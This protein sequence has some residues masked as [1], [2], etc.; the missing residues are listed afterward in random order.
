VRGR[1]GRCHQDAQGS[2]YDE[3]GAVRADD[4]LP[5]SRYSDA[6]MR[7]AAL[8]AVTTAIIESFSE[9]ALAL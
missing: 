4:V 5:R 7:A 6:Q 8:D 9:V 2:Q 3:Y 1:R